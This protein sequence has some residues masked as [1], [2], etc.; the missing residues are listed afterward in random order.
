MDREPKN[1][2]CPAQLAYNWLVSWLIVVQGATLLLRKKNSG[3]VGSSNA[4]YRLFTL[5]K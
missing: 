5:N 3:W 1:P 4:Y 2:Q